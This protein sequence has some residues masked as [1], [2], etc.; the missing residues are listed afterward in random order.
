MDNLDVALI[1]MLIVVVIMLIVVQM[2]TNVISLKVNVLNEDHNLENIQLQI[3]KRYLNHHKIIVQL[4]LVI[5]ILL[6]AR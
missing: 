6:V 5:V 4:E 2:D 1:L 3:S